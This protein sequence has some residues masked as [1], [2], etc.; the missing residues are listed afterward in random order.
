M[1]FCEFNSS[2]NLSLYFPP[3]GI[4]YIFAILKSFDILTNETV[5]DVIEISLS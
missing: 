3:N 5:I 1:N 2:S 4:K